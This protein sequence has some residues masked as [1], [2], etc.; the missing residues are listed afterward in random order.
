MSEFFN[1]GTGVVSGKTDLFDTTRT[2]MSYYNQFL[3]SAEYMRKETN[4]A[5]SIQYLTPRE[6]FEECAKIFGTST[7]RQIQQTAADTATISHLKRVIQE[8]RS[9]FPLTFLNYAEGTQEGRHRMYTAAE[10]TSWDTE[11]PV[12]VI[13]WADAEL[14]RKQQEQQRISE[15]EY[16]IERAISEALRYEYD[17]IEEFYDELQLRIDTNFNVLWDE[18]HTEFTLNVDGDVATIRK[19]GAEVSF[20][21]SDIQLSNT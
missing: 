2:G 4:L 7:E 18:P 10:L 1:Y 5:S 11:F 14:H 6:Y 9:Q 13:D 17:E 21:L 8:Q 12:L 20:N 19:D 16:R 15:D 3:A